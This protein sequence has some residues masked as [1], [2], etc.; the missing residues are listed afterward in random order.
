[1]RPSDITSGDRLAGDDTPELRGP[2][3]RPES[4]ESNPNPF[5]AHQ[6]IDR[7]IFYHHYHRPS[8]AKLVP[9]VDPKCVHFRISWA[10]RYWIHLLFVAQNL[11]GMESARKTKQAVCFTKWLV[12]TLRTLHYRAV[13]TNSTFIVQ[14]SWV[15]EEDWL[16]VRISSS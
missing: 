5:S 15:P 8:R 2:I 7:I 14:L 6:V 10:Q 11:Q 4:S 16:H 12:V 9:S 13:E 1:M 3:F